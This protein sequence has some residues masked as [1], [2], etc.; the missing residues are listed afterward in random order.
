MKKIRPLTLVLGVT[1]GMFLT[2]CTIVH[3]AMVT[4]NPVGSKT[5]KSESKL[6]SSDKG[7]SYSDAVK[8]GGIEKIGIGE[9]KVKY[10]L[11]PYKYTLIVTGE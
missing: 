1:V 2:S 10:F 3:T 5:G 9:A 4:N 8:K 11:V 7:Y 6:F